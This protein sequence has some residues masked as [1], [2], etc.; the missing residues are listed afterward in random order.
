MPKAICI[1]IRYVCFF[2]IVMES[3]LLGAFGVLFLFRYSYICLLSESWKS[4]AGQRNGDAALGAGF[5]KFLQ[6]DGKESLCILIFS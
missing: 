2:G 5:L 4:R 1:F 3:W 6:D